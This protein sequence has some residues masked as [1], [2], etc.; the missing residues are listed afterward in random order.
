MLG[1][2]SADK[3]GIPGLSSFICAFSNGTN[4][5]NAG[6]FDPNCYLNELFSLH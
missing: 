4:M 6:G 1:T 3:A 2:Q 5:G